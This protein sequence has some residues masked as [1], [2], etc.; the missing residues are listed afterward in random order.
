VPGAGGAWRGYL[1]P[2]TYWFLK[3][4]LT[5]IFFV[6]FRVKVEGRE[7]IPRHGPVVLGANHQSFCDSFFIPLV[8]RRKVT[9]LAKA[10]YFD[11]WKTAWFFR[12]AGQIPISRTGGSASERALETA[13]NEVLGRGQ[14]LGLYPEGTRSLDPN[15]HKGRTGVARLSR[16]CGAPVVPVGVI[17]TVDVQPVNSN[18]MRPFKTVIIRFGRPMQMDPPENPDDPLA[19]HDHTECRAFTDGLM[20]EIARLSEREYVDQYVPSRAGAASA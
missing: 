15:V 5:P 1:W 8:V 7:N 6:M 12:A 20:H 11:S 3:A 13:R 17:G 4:V 16:E 2:V 18:F 19:N 14:I 9:F 10:E